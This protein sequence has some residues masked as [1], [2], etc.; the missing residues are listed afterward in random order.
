LEL[1]IYQPAKESCY[2]FLTKSAA[3]PHPFERIVVSLLEVQHLIHAISSVLCDGIE[4]FVHCKSI[5]S[6]LSVMEKLS[7]EKK[8]E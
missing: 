1:G 7:S 3:F 6:Q 8:Q 2:L 5:F 4:S